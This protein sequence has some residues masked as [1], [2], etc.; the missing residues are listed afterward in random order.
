MMSALSD[1]DSLIAEA[2]PA[3]DGILG[4]SHGSCLAATLLLRPPPASTHYSPFGVSRTGTP[5][6]VAVFFSAGMAADHAALQADEV[7]MLQQTHGA[8]SRMIDIPTAHVFAEN[9]EIAPGQGHLLA[10]LCS[11]ERK[12]V[13]THRLGHRIPSAAERNDLNN[14]VNVIKAAIKDAEAM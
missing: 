12:H 9:D 10:G 2:E 8:A 5:F 6:K 1:L 3:Y 13:A 7:K 4:F 11:V 14:A